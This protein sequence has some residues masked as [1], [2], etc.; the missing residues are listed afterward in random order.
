[1]SNRTAVI[2]STILDLPS[3]RDKAKDACLRQDVF[4]VMMEQL[5]A[6]NADAIRVSLDLVNKADLYIGIFA[7]RYGHVPQ[8][9]EISISE[10]EYQRAVERDIP[11]H[12]FLMHADHPV[13]AADVDKGSAAEKLVALKRRLIADRAPAYFKSPEEL[14][15][16]LIDTL[17]RSRPADAKQL[18]Y[19]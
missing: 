17:A 15:S 8:G 4:P 11:R 9:S 16:Q 10:M 19:V 7:N 6:S 12:I 14:K 3:H 1:V 18:H 2:S 13:V 5:P